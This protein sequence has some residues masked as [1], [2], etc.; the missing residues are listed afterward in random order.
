MAG[1]PVRSGVGQAHALQDLGSN[2]A[3]SSPLTWMAFSSIPHTAAAC[4]TPSAN[5]SRFLTT[6]N[7]LQDLSDLFCI[8][9]IQGF[10]DFLFPGGFNGKGDQVPAVMVSM[11]NRSQRS[12]R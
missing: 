5:T 11:P 4:R 2:P 8:A 10:L 9:V 3:G 12:F 7:L 6:G 1:A